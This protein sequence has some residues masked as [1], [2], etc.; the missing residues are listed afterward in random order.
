V[1]VDLVGQSQAEK[2]TADG[3]RER[4]EVLSAGRLQPIRTASAGTQLRNV[5][6]SAD[7]PTVST[8]AR[9]QLS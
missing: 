8:P 2:L 3:G 6:P 4:F 9:R 7:I 1:Q 5:T